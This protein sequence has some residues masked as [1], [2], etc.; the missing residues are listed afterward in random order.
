MYEQNEKMQDGGQFRIC[1]SFP[2]FRP[3]G[4]LSPSFTHHQFFIL[5]L[6][7]I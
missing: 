4:L 2:N 3:I 7:F 1:I 5:V 6:Y